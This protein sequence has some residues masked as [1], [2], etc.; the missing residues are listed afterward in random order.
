MDWSRFDQVDG[1]RRDEALCTENVSPAF[2][3]ALYAG[4]RMAGPM[5]AYETMVPTFCRHIGVGFQI[6]NDLLDWEEAAP[7]KLVAG[8]D[9]EQ[10]KPTLLLAL[11]LDLAKGPARERVGKRHHRTADRRRSVGSFAQALPEAGRLRKG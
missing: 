11:A 1:S 2:E 10:A 3:A 8:R 5:E 9:A 6:L 7:N 4:L